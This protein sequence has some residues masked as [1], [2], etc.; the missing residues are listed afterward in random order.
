MV[1]NYTR[2]YRLYFAYG[3]D[4][5][6]EHIRTRCFSP[7]FVAVAKLTGHRL[8]FFGHSYIWDGACETVVSDDSSDVWG[9][10]YK[11]SDYEGLELDSYQ[12]VRLD[13]A[14]QYFHYPV[15]VTDT[16]GNTHYPLIYKKNLLGEETLPSEPYMDVIIAGATDRKLPNDYTVKLKGYKTK[17]ATYEVPLPT[18][19]RRIECGGCDDLLKKIT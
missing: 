10:V 2:D 16:D 1:D 9:V 3:A 7:E 14:G 11:L 12:D 6:D 19:P 4:M 17:Q 15:T 18:M 8:T 13:G 5:L